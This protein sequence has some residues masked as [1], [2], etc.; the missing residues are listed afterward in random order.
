MIENQV[1]K[2]TISVSSVV[3]CVS[4]KYKVL[5]LLKFYFLLQTYFKNILTKGKRV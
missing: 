4:C 5:Y 2:T 3:V 1:L